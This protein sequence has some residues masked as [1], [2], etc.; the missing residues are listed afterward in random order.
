LVADAEI[1]D[2]GFIQRASADVPGKPAEAIL[3][4]I[5]LDFREPRG[6][7]K[8]VETGCRTRRCFGCGVEAGLQAGHGTH[9]ACRSPGPGGGLVDHREGFGLPVEAGNKAPDIIPIGA[10]TFRLR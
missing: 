6:F 1:I 10:G 2:D 7:D 4:S 5:A 3:V 9:Q 8:L